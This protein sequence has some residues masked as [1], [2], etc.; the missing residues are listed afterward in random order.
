M[1]GIEIDSIIR[2][3]VTEYRRQEEEQSTVSAFLKGLLAAVVGG[4][5]MGATQAVGT[6]QIGKATGLSAGV[7]AI[8][9]VSAYLTK[10]PA[11]A[12]ASQEKK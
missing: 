5:S 6:G 8:L 3:V 7:G 10:S 1:E 2:K 4:A 9:A 12:Q 11:Q